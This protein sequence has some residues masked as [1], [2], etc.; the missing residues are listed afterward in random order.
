MDQEIKEKSEAVNL[1]FD[2]FSQGVK[3][4]KDGVQPVDGLDFLDEFTGIPKAVTGLASN[5]V[6]ESLE[7]AQEPEKLDRLYIDQRAKMIGAGVNPALAAT[8]ET[9]VKALHFAVIAAIQ[10]AQRGKV[11]E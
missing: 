6:K 5:W 3:S 4:F 1:L 2:F 10:S 8:I 7:A 11:T 9:Q